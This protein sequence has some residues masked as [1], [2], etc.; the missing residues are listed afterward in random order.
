MSDLKI[1]ALEPFNNY[2]QDK[3][4]MFPG[5]I[6]EVPKDTALELAYQGKVSVSSDTDSDWVDA[7]VFVGLAC[8]D[9]ATGA[10]PEEIESLS[11]AYPSSG[12]Y[13]P[14]VYP[15]TEGSAIDSEIVYVKNINCS[16]T[17]I[18]VASIVF[19][20][21]PPM[22]GPS[23]NP[24]GATAFFVATP[25]GVGECVFN[26]SMTLVTPGYEKAFTLSLP[27]SVEAG[28]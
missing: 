24:E 10:D 2:G 17:D 27:V 23:T 18:S 12:N 7:P 13:W 9:A 1:K 28:S 20:D 22:E 8:A 16:S 3:L 21:S 25:N 4:M 15:S 19:P 11:M 26:F 5:Q 6:A 14:I